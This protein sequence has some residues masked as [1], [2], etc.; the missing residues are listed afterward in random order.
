MILFSLLLHGGRLEQLILWSV[1][2]E[3]R[4]QEVKE[5]IKD[6]GMVACGSK[7]KQKETKCRKTQKRRK[8][9]SF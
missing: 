3:S 7:K 9:E 1:G 2:R 8:L 6:K 4:G 5:K